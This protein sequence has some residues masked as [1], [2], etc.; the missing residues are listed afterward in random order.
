M[1]VQ[2][3]QAG[4]Q[5]QL[6]HSVSFDVA[7]PEYAKPVVYYPAKDGQPPWCLVRLNDDT[8]LNLES[9]AD[10][11]EFETRFAAARRYLTA[12]PEPEPAPADGTCVKCGATEP[13]QIRIRNAGSGA[14]ETY[15]EL[16]GPC[17][18]RAAQ[19]VTT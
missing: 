17:Y 13:P 2:D 7:L 3:S 9:A 10:A 8:H 1:T 11:Q 16:P 12:D 4:T 15:C 6:H 5:P 19:A 14:M 18:Q